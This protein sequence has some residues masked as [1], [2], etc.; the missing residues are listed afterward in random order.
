MK[1]KRKKNKRKVKYKNIIVFLTIIILIIT[2]YFNFFCF[3]LSN[4]YI[5]GNNI[6]TDEE[7]IKLIDITKNPINYSTKKIEINLEKN[8]YILSAKVSKTNFFKDIHI[9]IIENR[10]LFIFKNK[11]ILIDGTSVNKKYN[12]PVLINEM[13]ENIY[14]DFLN[15]MSTIDESIIIHISEIKYDPNDVDKNR[16]L[17]TMNDGNYV[18]L[19][20]KT[21][22]NINN[23]LNIIKNFENKKGILYLDSGTYFKTIE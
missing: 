8:K 16:F 22:S 23:Y 11:T 12:V 10:P 21:L 20:L 4:I 5:D 15:K 6:L 9:N 13:N 17:F 1:K 14:T 7:I 2:I 18:Y 19:T 3:N